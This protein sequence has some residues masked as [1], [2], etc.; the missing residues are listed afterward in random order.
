M[1]FN[2]FTDKYM[3]GRFEVWVMGAEGW[4]LFHSKLKG[5][6][7]VDGKTIGGLLKKFE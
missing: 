4:Q 2:C 5:D 7:M 6:G 3:S 1:D